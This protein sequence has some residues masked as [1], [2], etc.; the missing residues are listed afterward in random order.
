MTETASSSPATVRATN[1]ITPTA[2]GTRVTWCDDKK[3]T[4]ENVA[5]DYL[6]VSL[7]GH[8]AGSSVRRA[9]ATWSGTCGQSVG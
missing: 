8:F 5:D 7:S 1:I 3:R 6:H 9:T 4:R 2:S